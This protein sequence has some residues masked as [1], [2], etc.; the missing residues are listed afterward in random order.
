MP[1]SPCQHSTFTDQ[2]TEYR[3]EHVQK[4]KKH[5]SSNSTIP[6]IEIEDIDYN[7]VSLNGSAFEVGFSYMTFCPTLPVSPDG[8]IEEVL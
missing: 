6:S 7:Y 2:V 5:G 3:T 1:F 8:M 4:D